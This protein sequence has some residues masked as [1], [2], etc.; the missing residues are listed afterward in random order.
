M[1]TGR[2]KTRGEQMKV[3]AVVCFVIATVLVAF[4]QEA[5]KASDPPQAPTKA[6][7][8]Y[9]STSGYSLL[10]RV[11]SSGFKTNGKAKAMFSYGIS[12]I[13]GLWAYDK[14]TA[15]LRVPDSKPKFY[16]VSVGENSIQDIVLLKKMDQKK[17]HREAEYCKAGAWTGVRLEN[18]SGVPL[19]VKRTSGGDI[20]VTPTEDLAV[21]EYLLVTG[22][23]GG[24][25]GYDFGIV[26][27]S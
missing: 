16:V 23:G 19:D 4:T 20:T 26:P 24:A 1:G 15:A 7:T 10:E 5:S 2:K 18:K 21:G 3:R 11:S 17:D 22:P 9:L 14:P 6:G 13:S 12:K 25:I 27:K 8:Y